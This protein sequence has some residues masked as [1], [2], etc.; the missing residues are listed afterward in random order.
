MA[1]AREENHDVVKLT[2]KSGKVWLLLC[3]QTCLLQALRSHSAICCAISRFG[4]LRCVAQLVSRILFTCRWE[5]CCLWI[6][7]WQSL[8]PAPSIVFPNRSAKPISALERWFD[9]GKAQ[10]LST[11]PWTVSMC[12]CFQHIVSEYFQV[13]SSTSALAFLHV[14]LEICEMMLSSKR[15]I[16][17]L[18]IMPAVSDMFENTR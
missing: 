12:T 4:V 6:R 13:H 18:A 15:S 16:F 8:K 2:G 3:M 17:D 9:S 11:P 10:E 5:T 1:K 7:A 14:K